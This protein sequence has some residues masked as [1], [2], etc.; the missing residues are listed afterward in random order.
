MLVFGEVDAGVTATVVSKSQILYECILFSCLYSVFIGK[1]LFLVS[2][3]I[4]QKS[5]AS[6]VNFKR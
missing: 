5:I 1:M 4:S 6:W 3:G 2:G